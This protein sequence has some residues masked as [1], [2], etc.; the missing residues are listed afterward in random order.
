M[1]IGISPSA[2]PRNGKLPSKQS[3]FHRIRYHYQGNAEGSTLR[4]TLGCLLSNTLGL[5]LRRV[6]SG[7]RLTFA[8]GE[9]R[10]SDWMCSNAF[11]VWA[12]CAEPW[13]VEERI[14]STVCLPLN[15]DQNQA[16]VFHPVLSE[17]RRVAKTRARELPIW[18]SSKP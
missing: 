8:D 11:V 16:N 9:Q 4:L 2:P 10:L 5:Q 7:K 6:G 12:E 14:I 1:Y 3:L 18:N 15:L 17:L 13:L